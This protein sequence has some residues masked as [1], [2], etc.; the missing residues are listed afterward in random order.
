MNKK[1]EETNYKAD[2]LNE[3]IDSGFTQL[4]ETLDNTSEGDVYKRQGYNCSKV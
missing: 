1:W 3:T 2:Q 4:N